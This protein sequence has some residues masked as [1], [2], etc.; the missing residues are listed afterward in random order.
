MSIQT[1]DLKL[2]QIRHYE[3]GRGA[4]VPRDK[5]YVFLLKKGDNYVNVF[6]PGLELPVY[7]RTLYSRTYY[8]GRSA[9]GEDYGTLLQLASGE[10][11]TGPCYVLEH[12]HDDSIFDGDTVTMRQLEA[13][14][15]NSGYFFMDSVDVIQ[16]AI[17][18][19]K[20]GSSEFRKRL[21]RIFPGKQLTSLNQKYVD[22][23]AKKE[24]FDAYLRSCGVEEK[25][26][27]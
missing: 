12:Y 25:H 5:A 14:V 15:M 2:A 20:A 4:E 21:Q 19:Y 24:K 8:D 23:L 13:Y 1:K 16:K 27:K 9:D 22:A 7:G 17:D 26:C 10:E 6:N 11:K 3:K 18:K